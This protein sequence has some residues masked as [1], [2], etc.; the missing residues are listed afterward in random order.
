M[1]FQYRPLANP[2]EDIRLLSL[3]HG[4]GSQPVRV[5]LRHT[6][7]PPEDEE[8]AKKDISARER[9]ISEIEETLPPGWTAFETYE[10]R[11]LFLQ[12]ATGKTSWTHPDRNTAPPILL[13]PRRPPPALT[14]CTIP[15]YEALSYL[16]GETISQ[17][18]VSMAYSGDD[19]PVWQQISVTQNLLTALRHLRQPKT[20]RT[21][22]IDALCINQDDNA[23]KA[24]QIL[25][26]GML[27]RQAR[28][29]LMW[30][31][32]D[33]DKNRCAVALAALS[34]MGR[35]VELRRNGS[36]CASPDA[37]VPFPPGLS[38]LPSLPWPAIEA[39]LARP[40]F[41]RVW[42]LQEVLLAQPQHALVLCGSGSDQV[43]SWSHF[44]RAVLGLLA[45]PETPTDVRSRA[46]TIS[47]LALDHHDIP[48]ADLLAM[49]HSRQCFNP[50]DHIYGVLGLLP[51]GLARAIRPDYDLPLAVVHTSAIVTFMTTQNSLELLDKCQTPRDQLAPAPAA[52][53][54]SHTLPSWVPKWSPTRH[55]PS[56][57]TCMFASSFSRPSFHIDTN[58]ND[59]LEV[60]GKCLTTIKTADLGNAS[61]GTRLRVTLRA[62]KPP[63]LLAA[64]YPAGGTFLDAFVKT[65]RVNYLNERWPHV[66]LT[67]ER[68]RAF[69]LKCLN[70][71]DNEKN[72]DNISNESDDY[73]AETFIRGRAFITTESGLVGLAPAGA[74]PGDFICAILGC[75]PLFLLRKTADNR[76]LIVGE[77]Y[78]HGLDDATAFLGPLPPGWRLQVGVDNY[79]NLAYTFHDSTTG[80]ST[81]EDPRLG[82]LP[83]SWERMPAEDS[84]RFRNRDTKEIYNGDPRFL[85][86]F[87]QQRISLDT[88]RLC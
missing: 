28:R 69:C 55:P 20:D 68:W 17:D 86:S 54:P 44:I 82:P 31:A 62:W 40:Y 4:E 64:S 18:T 3:L 70:T 41:T 58:N 52:D 49:G 19:S 65:L 80:K 66:P 9:T 67:L 84:V 71:D 57:G 27:Y 60:V 43:M 8:A 56:I 10:G 15:A 74:K 29:V 73:F 76:F 45:L 14:G 47:A 21:L 35:Q 83:G 30:L 7:F 88:L 75:D 22:W 36:L 63:A 61:A 85:P 37:S 79:A 81:V 77:A 16:W 32:P 23:E 78:V 12:E 53:D 2:S 26:M 5:L 39:L 87:L 50:R 6:F 72:D 33:P 51:P 13:E 59:T 24:K 38:G 46:E 1:P 48:V 25:R 34:N 11:C 42:I